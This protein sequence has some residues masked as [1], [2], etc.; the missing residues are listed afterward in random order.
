MKA[1]WKFNE[2]R[3][4]A[5]RPGLRADSL[6]VRRIRDLIKRIDHFNLRLRLQIRSGVCRALLCGTAIRGE[7]V[8]RVVFGKNIPK[9][10]ILSTCSGCS[11]LASRSW[12]IR[13]IF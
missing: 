8:N 6:W 11:R 2:S 7:M 12:I 4:T 3:L 1:R 9:I 13:L 5:L 10:N